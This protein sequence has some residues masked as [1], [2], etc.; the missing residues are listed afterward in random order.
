MKQFSILIL[1]I[2]INFNI[3]SQNRNQEYPV[4]DTGQDVTYDTL[5]VI[6]FPQPGDYFYGQD[7]QYDGVQFSFEKIN[8]GIVTDLNT[9]LSWQQ[10]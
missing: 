1:C 2:I 6:P 5:Y 10:F 8:D 3:N 9:G 7:A 4:I